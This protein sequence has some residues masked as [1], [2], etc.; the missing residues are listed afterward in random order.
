MK[1]YF[2]I[3]FFTCSLSIV[4]QQ[5]RIGISVGATNYVTNTDLLFSKSS[6]GYTFGVFATKEFNERSAL[7][8]EINYNSHFVKFIGRENELAIP[9]DIKFKLERISIPFSYNYSY[10]LLDEFKFG[11]NVGPSFEFYHDYKLTDESKEDYLLDPFL[12]PAQDLRFDTLS[13]DNTISF[14]MLIL[15]G[16]NVQYKENFMASFRYYYGITNTYRRSPFYSTVVE[17]SGK[18]SYFSFITTYLF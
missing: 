4:A 3:F 2:V 17:T 9:E 10:L 1:K 5:D 12:I 7:F 6:T 18:D 8:I 14:N 15:F 16:L 11:L 13:D